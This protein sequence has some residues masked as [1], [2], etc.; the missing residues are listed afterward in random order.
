MI[1]KII[2]AIILIAATALGTWFGFHGKE[3]ATLNPEMSKIIDQYVKISLENNKS[4]GAVTPVAVSTFTLAGSGVNNSASS[5]TLQSFTI[6]QS[7]Q[8][9]QDSDLSDTFFITLEPGNR[10]KQ[11]I[12]SCTT[13]IQNSN[14][15]ATLSGCSRGLAPITPYTA[16]TTLRFSH[17]GGTSVI[18]S[19]PP[20]HFNQYGAKSNDEVITG[21][22]TAPDP[23]SGQG[24]ATRAFVLSTVNGG[25]VST[26]KVIA[27][28]TAGE[29]LVAG[30]LIYLNTSDARWYKASYTSTTTV[31]D[32]IMGFSQG[33]GTAGNSI[34]GGVLLHGIDTN[35]SGLTAGKNYFAGLSGAIIAAT[36]TRGVGK[37]QTTTAIYF[38]PQFANSTRPQFYADNIFYG[39]N[40]FATTTTATTTITRALTLQQPQNV[41]DSNGNGVLWQFIA[42][43]TYSSGADITL[44]NI[45]ARTHLHFIMYL[46]D[47]AGVGASANHL[48]SINGDTGADYTASSS[49]F[50]TA[51]PDTG[52]VGFNFKNPANNADGQWYVTMDT[53]N[54][55]TTTVLAQIHVVGSGYGTTTAVKDKVL[56][57]DIVGIYATTSPAGFVNS[58][59]VTSAGTWLAGSKIYVYGSAF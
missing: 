11:E 56:L 25:T 37:A 44:S 27:A 20:Q 9:I 34:S 43:S 31:A 2:I 52:N 7:G 19:D 10:T 24:L 46:K 21:Y 54:L 14:G 18:F 23:I 29:T 48:I 38:D 36:T 12:V 16:S 8:K 55:S 40:T 51:A 22:W 59:K 53:Y 57:A 4:L 32:T 41:I 50:T 33:A 45:P 1:K 35:Q 6:T 17:A 49:A 3:E 47:G 15:T 30:N 26:D 42:S 28:G 13:V 39:T 5:I 58:I